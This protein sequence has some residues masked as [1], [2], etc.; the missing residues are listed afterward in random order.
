MVNAVCGV[1]NAEGK[2]QSAECG[3]TGVE[4]LVR[5]GRGRVRSLW[6]G[7]VRRRIYAAAP[8]QHGGSAQVAVV[9][10]RRHSNDLRRRTAPGV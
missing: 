1:G 4:G 6:N 7:S 8:F 5:V 10:H 2:G 9:I 3:G